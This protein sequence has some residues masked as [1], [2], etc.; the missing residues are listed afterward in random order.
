LKEYLKGKWKSI[1][2]THK[3]GGDKMKRCSRFTRWLMTVVLALVLSA[4]WTLPV[5]ADDGAPPAT[6]APS[7][8]SQPAGEGSTEALAVDEI[9]PIEAVTEEA[10][11]TQDTTAGFNPSAEN[12]V[13]IEETAAQEE[14][15]AEILAEVPE[16]TV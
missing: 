5:L 15:A 7:E 10:A 1:N 2:L 14:N 16:G 6:E 9:A 8:E 11:P 13:V 12:Q 3:K 4:M